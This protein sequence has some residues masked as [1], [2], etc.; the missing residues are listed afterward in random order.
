M[1]RTTLLIS[2]CLVY[3]VGFSQNTN[4]KLN[5]HKDDSNNGCLRYDLSLNDVQISSSTQ[6]AEFKRFISSSESIS[7]HFQNLNN[8]EIHF[9]INEFSDEMVLKVKELCIA[10]SSLNTSM[11]VAPISKFKNLELLSFQNPSNIDVKQKL[12]LHNIEELCKLKNLVYLSLPNTNV[13]QSFKI[14]CFESLKF[15]DVSFSNIDV[16][17]QLMKNCSSLKHLIFGNINNK[18][19]SEFISEIACNKTLNEITLIIQN[20]KQ[21]QLLSSFSGIEKINLVFGFSISEKK[22]DETFVSLSKID[23]LRSL[24]IKADSQKRAIRKIPESIQMLQDIEE[25]SIDFPLS[26]IDN[27]SIKKLKLLRLYISNSH[28]L[29][30]GQSESFK[31]RNPEVE[32]IF[33]NDVFKLS[34][35]IN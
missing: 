27:L 7:V 30:D 3:F 16:E 22:L 25:L 6:S 33:E 20:S 5:I 4:Y 34:T 14:C 2:V 19:V 18:I 9:V 15:L 31:K 32:I 13:N 10:F 11:D 28:Y 29:L 24:H 26:E 8:E 1:K 35:T 23:N 21:M 17:W 12:L